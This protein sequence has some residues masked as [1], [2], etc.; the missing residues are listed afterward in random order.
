[1]T[2]EMTLELVVNVHWTLNF[3]AYVINVD[4]LSLAIRELY[5]K[6][7]FLKIIKKNETYAS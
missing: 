2:V 6:L 7:N 3:I 1:M 5:W 4:N